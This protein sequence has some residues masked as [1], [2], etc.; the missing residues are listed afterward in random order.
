MPP[1][2]RRCSPTTAAV[3]LGTVGVLALLTQPGQILTRADTWLSDRVLRR[4][5]PVVIGLARAVS[6][7]GEPRV[8]YPAIA[9][10][11]ALGRAK[12]EVIAR[13]GLTVFSATVARAG[14]CRVLHRP[15]PPESGW[16]TRPDGASFP[17]RHTTLAALAAGAAWR[18]IGGP[19]RSL[20]TAIVPVTVVV[21]ASRVYLGVHWPTDVLAGGLFAHGWLTLCLG[22]R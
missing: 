6:L 8:A 13:I 3:S 11:G 20:L 4:R 14:L 18:L 1:R 22:E 21:G 19:D 10:A 9:A 5:R 16:R 2:L 17:S 15:R 12:P 7:L